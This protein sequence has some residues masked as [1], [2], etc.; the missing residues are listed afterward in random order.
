MEDDP[1]VAQLFLELLREELGYHCALLICGTVQGALAELGRWKACDAVLV[2]QILPDGLGTELI[3]EITNRWPDKACV[4]ITGQG[5]EA[6]AVA[7]LQAGARDYLTKMKMSGPLLGDALRRAF[8]TARTTQQETRAASELRN[9]QQDMDHF[10]K[11]ISHDM[12]A[13]LM[14]MESSVETLKQESVLPEKPRAIESITHLEACLRQSN[15]FLNDLLTLARTGT[16]EMQPETVDPAE[17]ARQ[18]VFEQRRLLSARGIE[19]EIA[20]DLPLLAVHGAR[21]K[22]VLT[23]LIRNAAKHGCAA[24]R[25]RIE[26]RNAAPPANSIAGDNHAWLCV[27]DNGQGIPAAARE[28]I[29][30]PG[31]RLASA[32]PKGTGMGL[33]IVKKIVEHYAGQALV[34]PTM[35]QGTAIIFALPLA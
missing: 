3:A 12:G 26:I 35:E 28:E 23:N 25:P 4:L 16:I 6:V 15:R 7:A 20:A 21:L 22:Q 9:M 2:D 17:T 11:A 10:L 30:I 5:S 27:A 19:V 1:C 32:H 31:R 8:Q 34:D 14:V 24:E 33:A 18:V 29:F 13:N